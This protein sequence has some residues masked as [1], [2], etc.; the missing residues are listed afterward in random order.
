MIHAPIFTPVAPTGLAAF[1]LGIILFVLALLSAR[2]RARDSAPDSGGRRAPASITWI[3]VQGVGIGIAGFGP[4]NATLDPLAP[5]ALAQALAVL[6]LMAS[7]VGLFDWASRTMGKN[8]SLVARTRGDAT[9]VTGGPFAYVRHPIYVALACFMVAMAVAY[10]HLLN[11]ILAVPIYA[12]GTALRIRYEEQLLRA[13][14]GPAY[15][16]YAGR[17]KRFV[18]GLF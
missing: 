13:E 3:I 15:D 6:V 7:G 5:A 16:A 4:I 17:V 14:F 12:I 18:P 1:G 10:G 2:A 9:L 11:L 8:W